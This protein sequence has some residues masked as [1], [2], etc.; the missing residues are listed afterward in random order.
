MLRQGPLADLL[1]L[2]HLIDESRRTLRP[3]SNSSYG[4][5]EKNERGVSIFAD[6]VR[7][8]GRVQGKLVGKPLKFDRIPRHSTPIPW[9]RRCVS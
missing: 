7:R 8:E 1:A 5:S 4:D 6:P 2:E 9:S 3:G